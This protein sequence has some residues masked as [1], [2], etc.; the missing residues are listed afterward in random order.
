VGADPLDEEAERT[1]AATAD[2]IQGSAWICEDATSAY[3]HRRGDAIGSAVA[4][5]TV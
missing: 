5:F 4:R 1:I 3:L 2:S